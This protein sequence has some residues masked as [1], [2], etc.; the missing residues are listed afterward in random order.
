MMS[1]R[2]LYPTVPR[3]KCRASCPMRLAVLTALCLLLFYLSVNAG[4]PEGAEV[5]H[6]GIRR[7]MTVIA[8]M[9]RAAAMLFQGQNLVEALSEAFSI[10]TA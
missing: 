5:L 1:Y 2:I 8:D 6:A 7:V 10:L 3:R 9:E 4:W